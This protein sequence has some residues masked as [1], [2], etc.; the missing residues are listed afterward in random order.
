MQKEAMEARAEELVRLITEA[1]QE[2][3]AAPEGE[4]VCWREHGV[5]K[6]YHVK[7]G[8]RVYIRKSDRS[9]AEALAYKKYKG[10]Q[11]VAWNHELA[12][13]RME[14]KHAPKKP[15]SKL[16]KNAAMADLLQEHLNDGWKWALEDY[17]TNPLYPEEKKYRSAGGTLVRS[18][19]ELIICGLY[20]KYM[21][22]YRYECR[23]QIGGHTF[24]PDFT[25]CHP[26]T[27][28]IYLHEHFGM[29]GNSQ[30]SEE[31]F[32]KLRLYNQNGWIMMQNLL[33]SGESA[34]SPLEVQTVE[35]MIRGTFC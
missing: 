14:T 29:L 9:L 18:K 13:L 19:S 6:W 26:Q 1:E 31:V 17:E 22:P 21:V 15:L 24:Y 11:I 35:N 3:E 12:V 2:V 5:D 33:I 8:K 7:N 27:G 30:Y 16:L 25:L 28:T 20:E 34:E 23:I 32:K 10:F 4:I